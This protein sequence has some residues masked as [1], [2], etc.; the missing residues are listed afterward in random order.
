MAGYDKVLYWE[1]CRRHCFGGVSELERAM[2]ALLRLVLRAWEACM[3][4]T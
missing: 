3:V 4:L 1:P 2:Y